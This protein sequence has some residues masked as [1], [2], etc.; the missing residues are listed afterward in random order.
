MQIPDE[1][2]RSI[3]DHN[4]FVEGMESEEAILPA[5]RLA[6][7]IVGVQASEFDDGRSILGCGDSQV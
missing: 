6:S 3:V 7:E 4:A 2:S 5:L 1:V